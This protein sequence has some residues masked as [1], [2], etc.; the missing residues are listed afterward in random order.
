MKI[1]AISFLFLLG[2]IFAYTESKAQSSK[3]FMPREITKAYQN[4]TRSFDGKPGANYFQNSTD[5]QIEVD[6]DPQTGLLKGKAEMFFH[7]NSPD[8]MRA[9]VL[10]LYQNFYQKGGA[11]RWAIDPADIHDGVQITL[12]KINNE[13]IDITDSKKYSLNNT[14]AIVRPQEKI[15]PASVATVEVEWSFV[16][17]RKNQIRY[18]LYKESSYFV[19]F[20]FPQI[21]VYDDISSWDIIDFNGEQEF[22]NDYGN[23]EVK[24][25][26]PQ[27][28]LVWATGVLQNPKD[29][30]S[31]EYLKRYEKSRTSDEVV[32]II[33]KTDLEK[34]K[35]TTQNNSNTWAYKAEDVSDFAFAVSNEYLWDAV[36]VVVDEKTGRR[37]VSQAVYGEQD[38]DFYE[39][40]EIGKKTL[41]LL[42]TQIMQV[43][44]PYPQMT[45]FAG[46]GGMEYPMM[47]NDGS[48]EDRDFTVFVTAH[49]I[50]H[51]YFPFMVGT[52]EKKYAWVDEGLV[53]Y[54]PKDIEV[55]LSKTPNHD[56]IIEGIATFG[57]WAG[58]E[59]EQPL[60]LPS[61]LV[62][63][64]SYRLQAYSRP[65]VAFH[66]LR[67][68]LGHE[69][70]HS[71]LAAYITRWESKHPTPWDLFFTFENITGEDLSWFWKSWFYSYGVPDLSIEKLT[72]V[73]NTLSVEIACNGELITPIALKFIF[74]DNT[75]EIIDFPV[76]VWK[77]G[78]AIFKF[79]KK[80]DKKVKTVEL[81]N[82]HIPDSFP[83]NN[84]K[85]VETL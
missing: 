74:E 27:N 14:N 55:A 28:Y 22:Y 6:F 15:A 31:S 34:G 23:F 5:Y 13:I 10:R 49:E 24:I 11:R 66:L 3:L 48:V 32:H 80:F 69:K 64:I 43:P 46:D 54:L 33:E 1:K 18:G 79:D 40:A 37:A 38:A 77:N 17:P 44:Y 12:L 59:V 52:N 29:V 21:A 9:I 53:T 83:E 70:F 47:V 26:V 61:Y 63:G 41:K 36:S 62:N 82:P 19:G 20:W 67:Q 78:D 16:M 45:A 39:V 25:N 73:N 56:P 35:I 50:S 72:S 4:G 81:G 2:L 8:S 30:L 60:I 75:E 58:R 84:I 57:N 71:A 7:N 51:S 76:S 85:D 42:S 68:Y 65:A